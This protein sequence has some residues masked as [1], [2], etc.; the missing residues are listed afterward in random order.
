MTNLTYLNIVTAE[1]IGLY[2]SH[3]VCLSKLTKLTSLSV[4]YITLQGFNISP[5]TNFTLLQELDISYCEIKDNNLN[6]ISEMAN[7]TRLM[8]NR[9]NYYGLLDN[10]KYSSLKCIHFLLP[11]INLTSLSITHSLIK[12]LAIL[13]TLPLT[14]LDISCSTKITSQGLKSIG[15]LNKLTMLAV[16]GCNIGGN[17]SYLKRLPNLV[18]LDLS[19]CPILE[20]H[21]NTITKLPLLNESRWVYSSIQ[22]QYF[23]TL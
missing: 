5:F 15:T 16:S 20:Q 2:T 3:L 18:E 10:G 11:L 13:I 8:M 21:I 23:T 19:G 6:D 9:V 17:I 1:Y 12:D 22:I 7:L 4:T 14:A